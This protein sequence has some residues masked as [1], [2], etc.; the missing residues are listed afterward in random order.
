[1]SLVF[2]AICPHPPIIIPEIGQDELGRTR[3]TIRALLELEKK[4]VKARPQSVIIVSPHGPLGRDKFNILGGQN[5]SGNFNQFGDFKTN[6]NL[7][8]DLDLA[9]TIFKEIN[10]ANIPIELIDSSSLDHGV[11]VP[12]FYLLSGR[13]NNLPIVE[14]GFS[15]LSYETHFKLGKIIGEVA[16]KAN[17]RI[18]FIA[19]GDLSHRLTPDAPAGY[20][21]EG[22]KFDKLL[23]KLIKEKGTADILRID[24]DFTDEAGECG[25]RSII[26]LLG[27]LNSKK[28]E[29]EIMSYEGPFGVGY[30]VANFKI[31]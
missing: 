12:L 20:S 1:M 8:N 29:P 23:V 17:K 3:K 5:L 16:K 24:P 30:L 15:L 18:A 6:L 27:A 13:L 7:R 25:L 21:Q 22:E 11:L 19:S 31:K 26:M 10:K 14:M 9:S 4:L 28:Y 2:G